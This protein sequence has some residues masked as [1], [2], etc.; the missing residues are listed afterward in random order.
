MT[1]P[2]WIERAAAKCVERAVNSG[3]FACSH[4]GEPEKSLADI[5]AAE[6]PDLSAL[7]ALAREILELEAKATKGPWIA[8]ANCNDECVLGPDGYLVVDAAVVIPSK[9]QRDCRANGQF[10]ARLRTLAPELARRVEEMGK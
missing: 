7:A 8:D 9:K 5:I 2:A 6:A 4:D 10:I 1:H 3:G